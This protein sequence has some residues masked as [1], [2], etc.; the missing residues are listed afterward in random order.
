M[1][2]ILFP[3]KGAAREININSLK[4]WLKK[5]LRKE[6]EQDHFSDQDM[7][8]DATQGHSVLV[9]KTMIYM[10]SNT[11]DFFSDLFASFLNPA[12]SHVVVGVAS[13]N[14]HK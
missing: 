7:I 14:A 8:H 9:R 4:I 12:P 1:L 13:V 11:S 3:Y 10:R 5:Q 6:Q 2:G